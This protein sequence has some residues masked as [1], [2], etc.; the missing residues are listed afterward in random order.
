MVCFLSLLL[1][2]QMIQSSPDCYSNNSISSSKDIE[3]NIK[4]S[5]IIKGQI[6]ENLV[7]KFIY[8]LNLRKNK[9]NIYVYLDTPGGSVEHGNKIVAEIQKHKIS[10]IAERA[11]SMGFVILQACHKRYITPYGRIMQHQMSYG[12]MNEKA[13]VESYV[14]FVDQLGEVLTEMQS[15]KIG[16]NAEEFNRKTHNDWWMVGKKAIEQ[17]CADQL[18]DIRCTVKL[19][20]QNYTHSDDFYEYTYSK[21]PLI[22]GHLSKKAV[23]GGMSSLF[24]AF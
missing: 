7:T 12:I 1:S 8:D 19:T 16:M 6:D 13:K 10:C 24:F 21:C 5:M 23:E 14:D 22:S 2:F 11:Y 9:K 17:R 18:A 4:N 15:Q 20:G 3:L